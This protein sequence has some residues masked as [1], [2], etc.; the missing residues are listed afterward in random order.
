MCKC[1][2]KL[3]I[4]LWYSNFGMWR[5]NS[6]TQS[7]PLQESQLATEARADL[8][9]RVTTAGCCHLGS[10]EEPQTSL[11]RHCVT[12]R[13]CNG[14]ILNQ[15]Y[16]SLNLNKMITFISDVWGLR[17]PEDCYNGNKR[18]P[19]S[20]RRQI[21]PNCYLR[22]ALS[23]EKIKNNFQKQKQPQLTKL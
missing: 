21:F 7:D 23:R 18:H 14:E 22:Q 13:L 3:H 15:S 11:H 8:L 20:E 17:P 6:V 2:F 4:K 16:L 1:H 19:V 9:A 12:L 10:Q 5:S